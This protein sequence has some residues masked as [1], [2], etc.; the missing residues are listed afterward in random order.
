MTDPTTIAFLLNL[1]DVL[2]VCPRGGAVRLFW[3]TCRSLLKLSWNQLV[4]QWEELLA[5]LHFTC[6]VAKNLY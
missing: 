1:V 4:V 6:S 5:S 2:L 3:D